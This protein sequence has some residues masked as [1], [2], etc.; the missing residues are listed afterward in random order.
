MREVF[1][2]KGNVFFVCFALIFSL[3]FFVLFCFYSQNNLREQGR[4]LEFDVAVLCGSYELAFECDFHIWPAGGS[5][6]AADERLCEPQWVDRW[7]SEGG[8]S[9]V[10]AVLGRA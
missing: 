6:H 7:V 2:S 10:A 1:Y 5:E 9:A 4:R 3:L 8:P